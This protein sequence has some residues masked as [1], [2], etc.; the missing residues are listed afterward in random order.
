[1]M[2]HSKK[3][4]NIEYFKLHY[5]DETLHSA[6][7]YFSTIS[8]GE[9]DAEKY[10][11]YLKQC[12]QLGFSFYLYYVDSYKDTREL[13]GFSNFEIKEFSDSHSIDLTA[14]DYEDISRYFSKIFKEEGYFIVSDNTLKPDSFEE[15]I[16]TDLIYNLDKKLHLLLLE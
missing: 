2:F 8:I 7:K 5:Y 13:I 6:Y 12:E 16:F 9:A 1:M 3:T 11:N 15:R 14:F 4:T 10:I